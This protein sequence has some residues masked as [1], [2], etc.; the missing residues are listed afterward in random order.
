MK[1]YDCK[2]YEKYTGEAHL[3]EVLKSKI[4]NSAPYVIF[5][6]GSFFATAENGAGIGDE[7]ESTIT[8]FGWTRTNPVFA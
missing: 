2:A 8:W 7:I 4:K 6:D 3:F 1:I 5:L